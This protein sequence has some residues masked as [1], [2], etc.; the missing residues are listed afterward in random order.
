LMTLVSSGERRAL[1]E[2]ARRHLHAV[3][4]FSGRFL[5]DAAS[6]EEVAQEVFLALWRARGAYA[7]RQKFREYLYTLAVNR[8]RNRDRWWRRLLGHQERL[9]L[10]PVRSTDDTPLDGLVQQERARELS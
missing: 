6:G 8:C 4:S 9:A 3:A 10:L 2:L 1:E 5:R 7:E